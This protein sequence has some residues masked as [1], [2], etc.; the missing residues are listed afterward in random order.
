MHK[1]SLY[2]NPTT[3]GVMIITEDELYE[4][5]DPTPAVKLNAEQ[6]NQF[7][8]VAKIELRKYPFLARLKLLF[9]KD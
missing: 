8:K 9:L 7:V 6:Y 1:N 2:Y 4:K 5:V 3:N